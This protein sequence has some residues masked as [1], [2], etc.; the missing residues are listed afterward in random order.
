MA[1]RRSTQPT[2]NKQVTAIKTDLVGKDGITLTLKTTKPDDWDSFKIFAPEY[3][4]RS[5]F[6]VFNSTTLGALQRTDSSKANLFYGAKQAIRSLDYGASCEVDIQFS[7]MWWME[8]PWNIANGG[9]GRIDL[10]IR[11][12]VYPPYNIHDD[13]KN[14]ASYFAP[15]HGL[16]TRSESAP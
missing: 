9:V 6:T 16:N 15:S 7:T 4:E 12:C 2:F 1:D 5:Y 3:D 10:P 11:V 13:Y 14:Q 8:E